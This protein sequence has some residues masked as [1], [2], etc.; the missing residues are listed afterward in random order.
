ME[1]SMVT[2]APATGHRIQTMERSSHD[3]A[4]RILPDDGTERALLECVAA[5][6][7]RSFERLY[8]DYWPRLIRFLDQVMRQ[9]QIVDDVLNETMLAVWQNA[10]GFKAQSRVSTWIFAIAYRKALK[11][12]HTARRAAPRDDPLHDPHAP[13]DPERDAMRAQLQGQVR[14]AL[15]VLSPEQRAVVELTYYHGCAYAEIA[16]IMECPVDTVKTRMFH[17]RRKLRVAMESEEADE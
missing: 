3:P 12:A 7:R 9:P 17:A 16:Q 8:R 10:K 6:D 13:D 14:R 5:G 11:A 4:R 1:T 2:A 15:D